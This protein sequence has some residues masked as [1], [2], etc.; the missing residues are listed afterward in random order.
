[1]VLSGA[2]LT[3]LIQ[4]CDHLE[5][6]KVSSQGSHYR[7]ELDNTVVEF[8][9]MAWP[10]LTFLSLAVDS[11]PNSAVTLEGLL[12]FA[13]HCPNLTTLHLP[14]NE[15]AVLCVYASDVYRIEL[16]DSQST[17]SQGANGTGSET[18]TEIAEIGQRPPSML[19]ELDIGAPWV[20]DTAACAEFL[21]CVFPNLERL[22]APVRYDPGSGRMYAWNKVRRL[23]LGEET[24]LPD[25]ERDELERQLA[26]MAIDEDYYYE[27]WD[28]ASSGDD[29][30][31]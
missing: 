25:E 13:K 16:D 3:P 27:G 4:S 18:A 23:V 17:L 14:V 2:D 21:R 29:V 30:E 11:S 1:V 15:T 28:S 10:S 24:Q 9:A 6:F 22:V 12:P 26:K 5:Y 19:R 7:F 20:H 31:D 8:M